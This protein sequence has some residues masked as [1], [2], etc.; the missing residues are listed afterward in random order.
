MKKI[1]SIGNIGS[2]KS[3]F[4]DLLCELLNSGSST[5][6]YLD[7]DCVGHAA[8]KDLNFMQKLEQV[9]GNGVT[10]ESISKIVFSDMDKL[11]QL[12]TLFEPYIYEQMQDF[13]NNSKA[14]YVIIE[15][16]AFSGADDKF[17]AIADVI[18]YVDSKPE[19]RAQR[20]ID[21]G[22]TLDDF[23]KRNSS[24]LTGQEIKKVADFVIEN[25]TDLDNL[26]EQAV[27]LIKKF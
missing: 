18:V 22:H 1:L 12:N 9:F 3:T 25:N 5:C 24:Q 10:K 26:K 13:I 15:E 27:D 4:S 21:K 2:G 23:E 14:D 16:S 8:Y 20:W 11:H 17:A 6:D 19:I 7:L